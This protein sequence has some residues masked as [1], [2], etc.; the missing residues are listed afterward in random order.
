M[1][2]VIIQCRLNLV[3]VFPLLQ[4]VHQILASEHHYF[5]SLGIEDKWNLV[6]ISHFCQS[7][8]NLFLKESDVMNLGRHFH[9]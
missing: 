6:V 9:Y 8:K 4:L 1:K 3:S 7:T 2:D 5:Q